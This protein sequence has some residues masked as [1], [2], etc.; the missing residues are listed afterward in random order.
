MRVQIASDLVLAACLQHELVPDIK[1]SVQSASAQVAHEAAV[2]VQ[3]L[4]L[5]V[6][7]VV[8]EIRQAPKQPNQKLILKFGYLRRIR[9]V[10]FLQ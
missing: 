7:F 6:K 5:N 4:N 2:V 8:D 10:A 1:R 9:L 3:V